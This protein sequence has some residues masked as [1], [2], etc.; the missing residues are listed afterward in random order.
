MNRSF[1][2]ANPNDHQALADVMFD[3]VRNGP[4]QYSEKQREAWVPEPRSGKAWNERLSGQE[5]ILAEADGRIVG[6]MTLAADGYIDFAYIRPEA[7]HTGLFRQML[8]RIHDRASVK[9]HDKLWVHASLMAQP[10]F[11]A[12][13]FTVRRREEVA[14]GAERLERFEMQKEL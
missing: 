3:A 2:W 10:A 13:G 4:S 7:Q 6:F 1:R 5:I 12:L 8:D 11:A 9:G 14:I